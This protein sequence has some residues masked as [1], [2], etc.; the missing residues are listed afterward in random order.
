VS[1]R[2]IFQEEMLEIIDEGDEVMAYRGFV[3][4]DF[5]TLK[6]AT[7]T[8]PAFTPKCKYGKQNRLNVSEIR[9]TRFI[10]KYRIHVER[11]IRRLKTYKMLHGVISNGRLL[12]GC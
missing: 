7:L 8:I 10:A 1:D 3:V 6:K 11:A 5:L 2:H 9:Q 12:I 4:R